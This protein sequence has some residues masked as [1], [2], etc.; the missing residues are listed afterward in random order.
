M[1]AFWRADRFLHRTS[2]VLTF[3]FSFSTLLLLVSPLMAQ[4][5]LDDVHIVPAPSAAGNATALAS[6]AAGDLIQVD[7]NL[8]LVPVSVTDPQQRL[9]T[10]LQSNNF[11]V[12]EGNKPQEIRHFSSEDMPVSVG[13]VVDTS[14]SMKDKM[15]RVQE[16]VKQFCEAANPLDE[17]FL[18][19][20]ADQPELVQDFTTSPSEIENKMVYAR[21][22]GSTALLDAIYLG[23]AKMREAKYSKKALLIISDGGDNHSRYGEWHVKKASQEAD[24][25][26]YAIGTFDRYVPTRE[27]YLG[28]ELLAHITE[29]TGGR[30]FTI[31]NVNDLPSVAYRVSVELRMQYVLGY[32]PANAPRDGKWHKIRVKLRLPP[33]LAVLQAHAKTGYY[34]PGK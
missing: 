20:F 4:T 7:V 17:F 2:R 1:S 10:G 25:A 14:G 8:V 18:I 23:L 9:V 16:A 29:P 15:E 26:I 22:K 34:A 19:T 33:R 24:T 13:L 6:V 21:A 31:S 11:Q 32:R 30:A 3:L 12:L 27:E 28:P 5:R